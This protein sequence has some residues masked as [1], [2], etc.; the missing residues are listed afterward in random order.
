MG[1]LVDALK[2]VDFLRNE[3]DD[4]VQAFLLAGKCVDREK[5]EHLWRAGSVPH[6]FVIPVTGECKTV[7]HGPDG[8]E[9]IDRFIGPGECVGLQSTLDGLSHPTSAEVSRAGAFFELPRAAAH[10]LLE[11]FPTVRMRAIEAI[12]KMYRRSVRDRE[13]VVLRPVPERLARFLLEHSCVRQS[14][15]AKVLVHATQSEIAARLGT[16]REVVARTLSD[17][18]ARGLVSRSDSGLFVDDW[19]GLRDLA[20]IDIAAEGEGIDLATSKVRTARFYLPRSEAWTKVKQS[21]PLG[22][23]DHIGDL[24]ACERA[25]CPA[26]KEELERQRHAPATAAAVKTPVGTKADSKTSSKTN[27]KSN[28]TSNTKATEKAAVGSATPVAQSDQ[29][30]HVITPPADGAATVTATVAATTMSP[31]PEQAPSTPAAAASPAAARPKKRS[32]KS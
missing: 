19:N 2:S 16:V 8:R 20:A 27:T 32:K 9:F 31:R 18:I 30:A 6:G 22:C 21:D 4:V 10:Q 3:G 5:G 14:N 25:G 28:T 23:M 26:A 1:V 15:G 13:D 29:S 17:F 11:R 7:S 24:S 12:G